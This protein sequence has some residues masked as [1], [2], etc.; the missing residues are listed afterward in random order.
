MN[1]ILN[2]IK[3]MFP[4]SVS[5]NLSFPQIIEKDSSKSSNSLIFIKKE[6]E[7]NNQ[8]TNLQNYPKKYYQ[9]EQ[10]IIANLYHSIKENMQKNKS[11]KD[12]NSQATK[13]VLSLSDLEKLV[14]KSF[15][16]FYNDDAY[17]NIM[18]IDEIINNEKSHLVAEFKDFLVLGDTGEFILKYYNIKDTKKIYKQILDYYNENLFIFPNYV[19]LHESKYIYN[20]IQKKQKIIDIQEELND[21]KK[22]K[23]ND[24]KNE[25]YKVFSVKEIESILNESNTSGI[26]KYFGITDNN[27]EN[28]ID[29]NE[30]QILELIDK[31]NV[32]EKKN[33]SNSQNNSIGN[34]LIKQ[35]SKKTNEVN[36]NNGI[37]SKE[38]KLNNKN[39]KFIKG[40]NEKINIFGL[41]KFKNISDIKNSENKLLKQNNNCSQPNLSIKNNKSIKKVFMNSISEK[42]NSKEK[43]TKSKDKII[44]K[45]MKM[46]DILSQTKK[47]IVDSLY[48]K[49]NK[50]LLN[51]IMNSTK[52][53]SLFQENNENIN[54]GMNKSNHKIKINKNILKEIGDYKNK[55][56]PNLISSGNNKSYKKDL[57]NILF[58]SKV[59]SNSTKTLKYKYK[60]INTSKAD[61]FYTSTLNDEKSAIITSN[62][63]FKNGQNYFKKE[64]LNN[65]NILS[66]SCQNIVINSYASRNKKLNFNK[67]SINYFSNRNISYKLIP[68]NL[69][70]NERPYIKKPKNHKNEWLIDSYSAKEINK[71]VLRQSPD[72]F[73]LKL[74]QKNQ[75]KNRKNNS[76]TLKTNKTVNKSPFQINKKESALT[77][78]KTQEQINNNLE[79]IDAL[80]KNIR[81]IKEN[82]KKSIDVNRYN[83]SSV[84][85][86]NKSKTIISNK[87]KNEFINQNNN[88]IK[89]YLINKTR[90]KSRKDLFNNNVNMPSFK[91]KT[92]KFA[93]TSRKG[94]EFENKKKI[95]FKT[96][97]YSNSNHNIKINYQK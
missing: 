75:N 41:D 1:I 44:D 50:K 20:N 89:V 9:N 46:N 10:Y 56:K 90:N 5:L 57:M 34:K 70:S 16:K 53:F 23:K 8:N 73:G 97:N 19:A 40:R 13:K 65:K 24:D 74:L 37:N 26:K 81:K 45:E 14:H 47:K 69:T 77:D 18:K 95:N 3:K 84:L 29:K 93:N 32:L 66:N 62:H 39:Q 72:S 51:K 78:R 61:N 54:N 31:I 91:I 25:K 83:L 15:I 76:K 64:Y 68:S 59:S 58:S 94:K 87:N 88:A 33:I 49:N 80:S 43:F 36:G 2:K 85:L 63:F 17:Y 71:K 92:L 7:K 21:N 42:N 52:N 96:I 30:K 22:E 6:E 38:K 60:K 11:K 79:K 48:N 4:N 28:G 82:L 86:N 55:S 35:E 12:S 67:T 27:T